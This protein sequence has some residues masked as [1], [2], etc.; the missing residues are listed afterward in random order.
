MSDCTIIL[1][2]ATGDLV[3]R[4]II[5]A[6]YGLVQDGKLDNFALIG[7]AL[8]DVSAQEMMDRAKPFISDV[9]Q[10]V[11]DTCCTHMH[12]QSLDFRETDG[13]DK[14]AILVKKIEQE[15]KLS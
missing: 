10:A 14:L 2:G 12:Y 11:W 7:A 13:F 3:K 6:I 8:S 9:N 5:P 1:L 4:K 15:Q